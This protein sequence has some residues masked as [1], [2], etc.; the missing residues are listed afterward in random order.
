[1]ILTLAIVTYTIILFAVGFS[2]GKNEANST[3][4][5]YCPN[6]HCKQAW[7][8][9]L[10]FRRQFHQQM[11]ETYLER[12]RNAKLARRIHNQRVK[13]GALKE[14]L[15]IASPRAALVGEAKAAVI[16]SGSRIERPP[17]QPR[18]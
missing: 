9:S 14:R 17:I 5:E 18:T 12:Y 13:I 8:D 3:R 10:T 6:K 16:V 11:T 15:A 7:S 4:N 2:H 1:M